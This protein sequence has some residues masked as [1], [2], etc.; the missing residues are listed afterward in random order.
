MAIEMTNYCK[1]FDYQEHGCPEDYRC[2][3]CDKTWVKLWREYNTFMSHQ[4]VMCH[5]CWKETK[6]KL[7]AQYNSEEY[8]HSDQLCGSKVPAIPTEEG[9]TFWGYCAVPIDGVRWWHRLPST[10]VSHDWKQILETTF[11]SDYYEKS[12]KKSNDY[13]DLQN[14]L[15]DKFYKLTKNS[16]QAN[17]D[18]TLQEMRYI[19]HR[20]YVLWRTSWWGMV[21]HEIAWKDSENYEVR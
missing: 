20:L 19:Q 18:E 4:S 12:M 6:P 21:E 5:D 14:P 13:Y 17:R 10:W 16:T 3:R 9:D 2:T 15:I 11:S 1:P 8:G 7:Y